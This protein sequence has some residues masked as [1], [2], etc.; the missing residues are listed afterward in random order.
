M[1]LRIVVKYTIHE[2]IMN[3]FSGG[4]YPTDYLVL[5]NDPSKKETGLTNRLR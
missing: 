1:M 4:N 5:T 3:L 2:S